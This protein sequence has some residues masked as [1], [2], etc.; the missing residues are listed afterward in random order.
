MDPVGSRF[1]HI[2]DFLAEFGK[3]GGEDGGGNLDVARHGK[4]PDRPDGPVI[5]PFS[6]GAAALALL[7]RLGK[8]PAPASIGLEA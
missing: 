2:P 8:M 7:M 5:V 6:D 1:H 4:L 3:I